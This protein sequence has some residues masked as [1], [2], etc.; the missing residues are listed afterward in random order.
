MQTSPKGETFFSPISFGI[1]LQRHRK[2][3]SLFR[4]SRQVSRSGSAASCPFRPQSRCIMSGSAVTAPRGACFTVSVC[5]LALHI[6]HILR[7]VVEHTTPVWRFTG[8][9]RDARYLL[10]WR[11]NLVFTKIGA[12]SSVG[13]TSMLWRLGQLSGEHGIGGGVHACTELEREIESTG[14]ESF[15]T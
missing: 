11:G 4:S 12:V 6:L 10:P 13:E 8:G 9:G 1:S 14:Q 5:Q 7:C 2:N 15:Q 3:R